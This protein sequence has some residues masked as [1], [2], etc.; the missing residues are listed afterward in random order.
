MEMD[1]LL[2]QLAGLL[3]N[4]GKC[5]TLVE[6]LMGL[7][8]RNWRKQLEISIDSLLSTAQSLTLAEEL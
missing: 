6:N 8:Y 1:T 5:Y 4:I 3:S 7:K 2:I